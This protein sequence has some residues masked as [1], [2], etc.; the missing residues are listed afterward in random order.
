MLGYE[1][2]DA[3]ALARVNRAFAIARTRPWGRE[4]GT[5]VNADRDGELRGS[6]SGMDPPFRINRAL[7]I[8]G[9]RPWGGKQGWLQRTTNTGIFVRRSTLWVTLPIT[10]P[11]KSDS[12]RDP[13]TM[14]PTS[15]DFAAAT[16]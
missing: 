10:N 12:P 14:S 15:S 3:V 2:N 6:L 9:T 1:G 4:Q 8:A 11:R 5:L 7:T 16:M 13:M